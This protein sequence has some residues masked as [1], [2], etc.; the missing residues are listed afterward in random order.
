MHK[1]CT[2][3]FSIPLS[4]SFTSGWALSF[5]HAMIISVRE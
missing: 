3:T 4:V 5:F 2:M 1:P